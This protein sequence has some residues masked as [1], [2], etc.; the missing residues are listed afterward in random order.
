ME[1]KKG[2]LIVIEGTDGTGKAT[3]AG[4]LIERLKKL[5]FRVRMFDFPRYGENIFANTVAAYLRH[6]YGNA[7]EVDPYLASL[8][9]SADRWKASHKMKDDLRNGV[10]IVSNRYTSASMGHQGSKI[11]DKEKRKAYFEWLKKIEQSE[12]GFGIPKPDVTVLLY[13]DPRI[14]QSLVDKK[15]EREYMQGKK[16]DGHESSAT[17]LQ[18]AAQTFLEIAKVEE[19]WRLIDCM[20]EKGDGILSPIVISDK[21]WDAIKEH[22]I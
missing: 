2:K 14:S 22:I 12:E 20:N 21:I 19:N 11:R 5:E 17:H 4:L 1:E 3:Q 6:E 7:L 13:L 16:R 8:P 10:I 9:Y 18:E 15:A